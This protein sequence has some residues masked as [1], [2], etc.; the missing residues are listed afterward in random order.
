MILN[1]TGGSAS[2][3]NVYNIAIPNDTPIGGGVGTDYSY[4]FTGIKIPAQKMK[5]FFLSANFGAREKGA[6]CNLFTNSLYEPQ[7]YGETKYI[8]I[9][10]Y[11][12]PSGLTQNALM[13]YETY[14]NVNKPVY[15]YDANA[16]TLTIRIVNVI[17]G[18]GGTLLKAG[19]YT[20]VVWW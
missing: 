18:S 16:Q 14:G 15:E 17:L 9:V 6:I 2:N 13:A 7:S 12:V 19:D 10:S 20:L 5:G 1:I 11:G 4:T 3:S 8:D